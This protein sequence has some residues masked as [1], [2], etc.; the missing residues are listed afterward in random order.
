MK[1]GRHQGTRQFR[2]QERNKS[3]EVW[4]F[5]GLLLRDAVIRE[6][7]PMG[8]VMYVFFAKEEMTNQEYPWAHLRATAAPR[9]TE[10]LPS[11]QYH[12]NFHWCMEFPAL[13]TSDGLQVCRRRGCQIVGQS[14]LRCF[15]FVDIALERRRRDADFDALSFER[16][17]SV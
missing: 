1:I 11:L 12:T 14:S 15:A 2:L 16:I 10:Y 17:C 5:V 8:A 6:E 4:V 9:G 7:R 3:K 13:Q